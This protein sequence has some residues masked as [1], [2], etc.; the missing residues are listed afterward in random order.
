MSDASTTP[1]EPVQNPWV[2]GQSDWPAWFVLFAGG[3]LALI[4]A[5]N[6]LAGLG[7][8]Q[9]LSLPD[10]LFHLSLRYHLLL[11][12]MVQL[13]VAYV[14]LFTRQRSLSLGLVVWLAL[15]FLIYRA[16][17]CSLNW[18]HPYT[19]VGQLTDRLNISPRFAEV[20]LVG[21]SLG[22]LF[23]GGAILWFD[24]RRVLAAAFQKMSCPACG[25]H[26]KFPLHSLGQKIDC[27]HCK[28][29]I[30]LRSSGEQLKT[31][32]FFCDGHI[33]FPAHALG[34]KIPCPHCKMGI[35]L[36]EPA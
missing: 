12:G 23:G 3:L 29:T 19:S 14:C 34:Q 18:P 7:N 5:G 35:T 22:L 30:A 33:E 25:G 2:S 26:V 31:S 11:M 13:F 10:P 1:K 6:L 16:G 28:A 36:K 15:N 4:G 32:C 24:R 20:I 17:L 8:S 27:P 9:V 21:T